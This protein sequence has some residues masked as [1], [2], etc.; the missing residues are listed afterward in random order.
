M[1]R[2]ENDPELLVNSADMGLTGYFLYKLY[3]TSIIYTISNFHVWERI[4]DFI[5]HKDITLSTH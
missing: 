3:P 2:E 5:V 1:K 4:R